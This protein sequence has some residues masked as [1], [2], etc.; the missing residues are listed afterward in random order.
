MRAGSMTELFPE[1]GRAHSGGEACAALLRAGRALHCQRRVQRSP[2]RRGRGGKVLQDA[3]AQ[4]TARVHLS[5]KVPVRAGAVCF[6]RD[7]VQLWGLTSRS[8][9]LRV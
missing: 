6:A 3:K 7:Y 8:A 1:P 9:A 5:K 2:M 4:H